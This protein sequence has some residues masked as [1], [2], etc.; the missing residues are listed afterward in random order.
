[1]PIIKSAAKRVRQNAKRA[2]INSRYKR[3]M[4]ASIKQLEADIA[5]KKKTTAPASLAA[6]QKAIDKAVKKGVIHQNTAA[7][8]KSRLSRSFAATF[9][10]PASTTKTA[11]K[12]PAKKTAPTKKTST[13]K[14]AAKKTAK[15]PAKKPATKSTA[16]KTA[17]KKS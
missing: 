6:A 16:K 7:R 8:R 13:K 10:T 4:R 9:D 1:M 11:K 14:P 17:T 3:E 5:T 2:T 15:A 12:T